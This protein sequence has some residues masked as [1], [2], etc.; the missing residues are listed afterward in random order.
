MS[1]RV[2]PALTPIL[3]RH[4]MPALDGA[5]RLAGNELPWRPSPAVV[6]AA[7]D[8]MGALNEYPS[9]AA[10][11]LVIKLARF[12]GVDPIQL[13]VGAGSAHVLLQTLQAV[14]DPGDQ[15]VF[16]SPSFEAY[17]DLCRI[18]HAV[19]VTVPLRDHRHDLAAMFDAI[20]SRTRVL[21]ICNPDNP[22]GSV[23]GADELESFLDRV[24]DRVLVVL[25][26]A[27]FEF[28]VDPSAPD[29]MALGVDRRTGLGDRA[30]VVVVRTF[31]KARGLGAM[32]VGYGLAAPDVAAGIR[33]CGVPYSVPRHA[34]A[35][36][37]VAL[38]EGKDLAANRAA[39][40]HERDRMRAQLLAL[41]YAV[42]ESHTNFLW[43]DVGEQ[44][45]RL[46]DHCASHK[47]LVRA[48]PGHGVRVTIGTADNNRAFIAAARSF[49]NRR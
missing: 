9:V 21:I 37:I 18:A 3:D 35:A 46:R 36:A 48:Y 31:S 10:D 5:A 25:D 47:I 1:V 26:E 24:P 41:D 17:P 14:C 33:K 2:R 42:P 43:L 44:A 22:T 34:E 16:A 13:A 39:V 15:V 8:E 49:T 12:Y 32:R 28:V 27:Y 30:N 29:G 40:I 6:G 23:L 20:T 11:V 45:Q 19:P 4:A 7:V 38:D